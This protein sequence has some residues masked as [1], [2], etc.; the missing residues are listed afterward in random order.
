M[1]MYCSS[2]G[3]VIVCSNKIVQKWVSR[4]GKK[5]KRSKMLAMYNEIG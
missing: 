2:G 5:R 3:V 1:Y 4:H